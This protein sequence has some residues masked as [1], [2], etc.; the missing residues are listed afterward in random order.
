MFYSD[1]I[2]LSVFVNVTSSRP[3][4]S[5]AVNRDELRS[6]QL[7]KSVEIFHSL[8]FGVRFEIERSAGVAFG[9]AHVFLMYS[10]V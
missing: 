1:C 5:G 7:I 6:F 3:D 9:P 2:P 8:L 4:E 10:F